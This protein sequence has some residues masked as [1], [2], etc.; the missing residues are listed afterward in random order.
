MTFLYI[1]NKIENVEFY[2]GEKK[3]EYLIF[4]DNPHNFE[5][6]DIISVSGLSTTSS[7]I[8][9]TYN[10]GIQTNRLTIAGVGSTGVAIGTDGI[11]GIVTYFKVT[12]N[13]SYPNIRENDILSVGAEKIKVLN[14]D[15]LSSRIRV[16]RAVEGTTGTSHTV[17]KFIYE[18]PRKI[19]IN[20]N[21]SDTKEL[22]KKLIITA[23]IN[24]KKEVF[25]TFLNIFAI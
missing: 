20:A 18:V 3:G 1:I 24:K 14:V 13:I 21:L 11:T 25:E 17:G 5:N 7:G 2:P 12:G 15:A 22:D 6:L 4:A 19:K 23:T 9:G 10:A 16:L 8:E